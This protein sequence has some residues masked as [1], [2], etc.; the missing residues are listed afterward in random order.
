MGAS[1]SRFNEEWAIA[2]ANY[3]LHEEEGELRHSDPR[4]APTVEA[5]EKVAEL[6]GKPVKWRPGEREKMRSF[7][8]PAPDPD[9]PYEMSDE[10]RAELRAQ[11]AERDAAES[12]KA[13]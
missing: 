8:D 12:A 10:R 3:V 13:K 6:V 9:A 4:F 5:I 1:G 2:L 11:I 7:K